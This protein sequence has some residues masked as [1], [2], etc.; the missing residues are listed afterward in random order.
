MSL[1]LVTVSPVT[2]FVY[3][4]SS[5]S[6]SPFFNTVVSALRPG[7]VSLDAHRVGYAGRGIHSEID[8]FDFAVRDG[9]RAGRRRGGRH[10]AVFTKPP[11][12]TASSIPRIALFLMAAEVCP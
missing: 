4:P 6:I 12:R 10:R 3:P 8:G 2:T 5:S 9:F 1:A 7:G 11:R